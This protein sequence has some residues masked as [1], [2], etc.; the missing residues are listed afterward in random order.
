MVTI[1]MSNNENSLEPMG[2]LIEGGMQRPQ[3]AA[4]LSNSLRQFLGVKP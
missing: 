3:D 2:R 1:K 4:F